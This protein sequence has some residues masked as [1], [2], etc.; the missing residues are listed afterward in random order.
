[1]FLAMGQHIAATQHFWH[2]NAIW[3]DFYN[4]LTE[5]AERPALQPQRPSLT[6]KPKTNRCTDPKTGVVETR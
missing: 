2:L 6:E 4:S 5:P 1:M 3:R